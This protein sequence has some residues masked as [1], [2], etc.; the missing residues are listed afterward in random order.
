MVNVSH[1]QNDSK[2]YH[3][4]IGAKDNGR[5][6]DIVNDTDADNNKNMYKDNIKTYNDKRVMV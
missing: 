5:D 3:D 6:E 1:V 4:R 2:P